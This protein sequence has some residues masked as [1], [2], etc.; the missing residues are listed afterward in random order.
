MPAGA[1]GEIAK[2]AILPPVE[3]TVKPV[4]T[5]LTVLL[6]DAEVRVKAGAARVAGKIA[7]IIP[8]FAEFVTEVAPAT[9]KKLA[10]TPERV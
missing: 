10:E 5:V 9:V 6:S 4:A 8:E 7:V 2:L 1:T 3:F